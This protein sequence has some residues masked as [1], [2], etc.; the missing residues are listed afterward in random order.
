MSIVTCQ[1][2]HQRAIEGTSKKSL[3]MPT[4]DHNREQTQNFSDWN[5]KACTLRLG[6]AG[7]GSC[8]LGAW[9]LEAAALA[10]PPQQTAHQQGSR[11]TLP[12][13]GRAERM[14]S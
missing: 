5:Q 7:A 12:D 11:D 13:D 2:F 6:A 10:Y 4:R 8:F 1:H 9:G 3:Y 14:S